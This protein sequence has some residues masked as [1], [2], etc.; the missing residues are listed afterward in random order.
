MQGINRRDAEA[1]ELD[2][3]GRT[4]ARPQRTQRL[5]GWLSQV[6]ATVDTLLR[7]EADIVV[8]LVFCTWK[9]DRMF[10]IN[11]ID[12]MLSGSRS[13]R[14]QIGETLDESLVIAA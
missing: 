9:L 8:C 11:K 4:F 6:D 5:C 12:E 14:R 3:S 2:R 1:R 10:R 13:L 7:E